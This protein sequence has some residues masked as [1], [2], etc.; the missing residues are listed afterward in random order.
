MEFDNPDMRPYWSNPQTNE[1]QFGLLAFD[2]GTTKSICY[3]D[4]DIEEWKNDNPIVSSDNLKLFVKSDEKYLYFMAQTKDYDFNKD[5]LYIPID[6]IKGQGNLESKSENLKFSK[7]VD[8][9][10]KINGKNQSRILVDTYYDGFYWNYAE[11]Q[12]VLPKNPQHYVMG[13]NVFNPMY[14]CLTRGFLLPEDQ[15]RIPFSKYET[16]ILTYGN[17]NPDSKNFNSLADFAFEN[18]NIEIRIPWQLLNVM[19]PS[20]KTIMGDLYKNNAIKGQKVD[21]FYIG[22]SFVNEVATKNKD[23]TMGYYSWNPWT[24]PTFHERLKSS[25]YIIK[26]AFKELESTRILR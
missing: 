18:G 16:G 24:A 13:S 7:A 8:F 23:I 26:D 9:L 1:Q 3:V 20:T 22:A 2:P 12:R 14:L 4:G 10:I 21:G 6:T 15:I 11:K 17:A 19:D 25:Y 5:S